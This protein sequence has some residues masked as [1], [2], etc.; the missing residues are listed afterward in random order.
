MKRLLRLSFLWLWVGMACLGSRAGAQSE[1]SSA[2]A[3]AAQFVFVIDDSRSMRTTDPDRLSILAV[4]ALLSMLDGRDEVSIVRLNGATEAPPVQPL[5][6]GRQDLE[7]LLDLRGTLAGYGGS[8]T[9][10]RSALEATRRLLNQAH[11]PNVTQV[12]FFLTDGACTPAAGETPDPG[13][14]LKG[15]ESRAEGLFQFYLL[16]FPGET[17]SPQLGA[18]ARETGGD[19]ISIPGADATAI[20]HA[21]A[22]AL[23]RSQGYEA[24][25]LTPNDPEVA[26]HRGAKRVR[27]LAVAPGT[28]PQL[29]FSIHD[30]Q[31]AAPRLLGAPRSGVHQFPGGRPFRFAAVDYRPEQGPLTLRVSGAETGWKVV[32]LPEYRLFLKMAALEGGCQ[33]GG[34]PVGAGLEVGSTVCFVVD[35]VNEAG[36]TVDGNLT[37]RDIEAFV[38]MR[39]ADQP[40]GA[41]IPLPMEPEG[42]K[43]RFRLERSKLEKADWVF[44]PVLRLHLSDRDPELGGRARLIQVAS[45]EVAAILDRSD[46]GRLRPGEEASRTLTL[47]GNF[48]TTPAHLELRDRQ[49]T[50]SC[51]TFELNSAP[52]GKP[53]PVTA[54]QTYTLALRVAPYCGPVSFQRGF[55]TRL[56]LVFDPPPGAAYLPSLDIPISFSV[57]DRIEVP[58]A[59]V[60]KVRGGE[61]VEAG[62][63]IEGNWRKDLALKGSLVKEAPE[64]WRADRLALGF[65]AGPEEV[66]PGRPFTLLPDGRTPLAVRARAHPCCAA[67][68]YAGEIRLE[69]A[70]L[71]GYAPGVTPPAPLRIPVRVEVEAA[72][73]W[74]CYKFWILRGLALLIALALLLY[75]V[76]MIRHSHF[77]KPVRVAEK[78]VPLMW[79]AHGATVPQ[80]DHRAKVMEIVR[81]AL[82]WH[83]RFQAWL[84]ANPF[85]F[86]LPGGSYQESL[87]LFLQP[88]R[89]A[90]RSTAL[91]VPQRSFTAAVQG[92]PERF[93]GRLFATSQGGITFLGVPDKKGRIGPLAPE[94]AVPAAGVSDP[95]RAAAVRLKGHKL[96]RSLDDWEV[97]EEGRAAGWQV[98]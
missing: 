7:S 69:P 98:G 11:R 20:L 22:A 12:V 19:E 38:R 10:C 44:Q 85:A 13:L 39:R 4:K 55:G 16:R 66:P 79:T 94:G 86:G 59:V 95:V 34:R 76:N 14:F 84:K 52:E 8:N 18:L 31:G 77:L 2:E 46:F 3:R 49:E 21:F 80:K 64:R 37:G 27:L 74:A 42:D 72:G 33:D 43:A 1:L 92:E 23:S 6:R 96:L 67:G 73:L 45:S 71:K 90:S 28:G 24:E 70:S 61:E 56:R 53:Q 35:L 82:P 91:L 41:A 97:A 54:N 50:P 88:Q 58:P 75:A 62:L 65:A 32:A 5:A 15:L 36:V 25:L 60:I 83:R 17:P 48:R 78:L 30:Q 26:A 87:E 51:I 89:D 29:G 47:R 57:E 93:A 68:T 63:A 81:R 9:L 40:A